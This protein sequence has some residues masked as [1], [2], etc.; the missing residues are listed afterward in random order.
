MTAFNP[1][2]NGPLAASGGANYALNVTNGI[3]ALSM[4]GAALLITDVFSSGNFA[5]SG[6]QVDLLKSVKMSADSGSYSVTTHTASVVLGKGLEAL[7]GAF[8]LTGNDVDMSAQRIVDAES[9][10]FSLSGQQVPAILDI[11]YIVDVTT[12]AITGQD[13]TL[14]LRRRVDAQNGAFTL[15]GQDVEMDATRLFT[16][17]AATYTYEGKDV[18]FRGFLSVYV[19]PETWTEVA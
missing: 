8:T 14:D 17:K 13:A 3:F 18:D 10:S 6:T 5:L 7:H 12:F 2:A 15:T 19:P 11:S 9:G 4:Q 16:V 1:I